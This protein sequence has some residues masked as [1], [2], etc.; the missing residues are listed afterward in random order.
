VDSVR[1]ITPRV[2]YARTTVESISSASIRS[3]YQQVAEASG[4]A[5]SAPATWPTPGIDTARVLSRRAGAEGEIERQ[6]MALADLPGVAG[7][8]GPV[9]EAVLAALPAWAR[10]RAVV[11]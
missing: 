4:I 10:S 6:W 8:E 5:A 9:R 1:I 2:R 11:D 3:L 7:H